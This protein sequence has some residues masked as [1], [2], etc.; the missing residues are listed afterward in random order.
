ML[1]SFLDKLGGFFDRRF[2]LAYVIPSLILLLLVIG[3]LQTFYG[4]QPTLNWWTRLDGQEKILFGVAALLIVIL[5]ASTFEMITAP[6]V[7]LYEGYWNDG[8]LKRLAIAHHKKKKNK[9]ARITRRKELSTEYEVLLAEKE[10]AVDE[11]RRDS[12]DEQ[13]LKIDAEKRLEEKHAKDACYYTFPLDDDLLKPTRLGNV[14]AAAEEYSHQVYRLDAVIWWPRLAALL[15]ESFRIQVDAALTPMLAVLNLS[16]IFTF[17][18]LIEGCL[19]LYQHQWLLGVLICLIGSVLAWIC[20]LSSINQATVYGRFVRV[21]FDLYRHEVLKKMH[22]PIPNNPVE[23]RLMWDLLTEWHYFYRPPWEATNEKLELD[24]PFYYD[25]HYTSTDAT[26]QQ[27][28]ILTLD[29][30]SNSTIKKEIE[31]N[32]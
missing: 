32:S 29:G 4:L 19:F 18:A 31:N 15:P 12:I 28:V 20:Y 13:L 5:L 3:I 9:Y 23:E 16:M 25:T 8:E 30:F 26:K 14:L 2:I 21:A 24:N 10:A 27:E 1:G 22:I 11:K 6:V 17:S 7:R